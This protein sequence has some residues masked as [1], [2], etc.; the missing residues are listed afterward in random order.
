MESGQIPP[1]LAEKINRFNQ[2]QQAL[3]N[4]MIQRQ[5]VQTET[6]ESQSALDAL[7]GIT[8]TSKVYSIVG[9]ILIAKDKLLVTKDLTEKMEL[10]KLRDSSLERQESKL[11]EKYKELQQELTSSLP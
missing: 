11:K 5:Q 10:L 8:D 7:N 3:E 2:V 1:Q 9:K 6:K 4:V